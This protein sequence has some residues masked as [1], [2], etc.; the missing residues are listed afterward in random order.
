MN[1]EPTFADNAGLRALLLELCTNSARSWRTDPEARELMRFCARRYAALART[2]GQTPHDAAVAAFLELRRPRLLEKTDP[3]AFVTTSV[4][5]YLKAQQRADEQLVSERT[6]RHREPVDPAGMHEARRFDERGWAMLADRVPT[7]HWEDDQQRRVPRSTSAGRIRPTEVDD[8]IDRTASVLAAVGWELPA[9]E[10]AVEYV[11][12]RLATSGSRPRAHAYLRRDPHG[13]ALLDLD[14][15][16]WLALLTAVLGDPNPVLALTP[17]GRGV[18]LSLLLGHAPWDL[19][20]DEPL[21]ALLA[22]TTP[23][24]PDELDPH[25]KDHDDEDYLVD[26]SGAWAVGSHV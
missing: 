11:T 1:G 23:P 10:V 7:R 26:A 12:D 20:A 4:E 3:W 17:R 6:A 18:L 5:A 25:D 9:A 16:A 13:R 15:P 2:Y 21:A 8:A 19:L 22:A 14:Q 24:P